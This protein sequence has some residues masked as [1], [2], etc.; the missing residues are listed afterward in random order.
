MSDKGDKVCPICTEEMDLTDQQ[1]NPCQCGYQIC[2]WCW[3]H[4]MEMAEKVN[5][6]GRCPACRTAY[7][8]EKIVAAAENCERLVAEINSE[9]KQK[10][11]KAKPKAPEGKMYLCDFRVIQRN[12]VYIIGLPLNLADEELL[13]RR[14]Y[15]GQYGKV[16]K[17]SISRTTTGA[18]QH[19]SNNSC[20]VYITYSKEDDAIL[21]IQSVHSFVLDGRPLRASFGT[22]KYCHAW[23]R[24]L[25]CINPDCLYLHDFGSDEDRFFKDD[26]VLAFQRS[27]VQQIIGTTNNM[28]RSGDVLPP[29]A[30][31]A[32]CNRPST[33]R[34]VADS[35]ARTVKEESS[36]KVHSHG[37]LDPWESADEGYN[38]NNCHNDL[39]NKNAGAISHPSPAVENAG[40]P[41]HC[42]PESKGKCGDMSALS[43]R[44][45]LV[46]PSQN[47]FGISECPGLEQD[48]SDQIEVVSTSSPPNENTT[49]ANLLICNDWQ[50]KNLEGDFH[51]PSVS[52]PPRSK[53]NATS[54]SYSS[55]QRD[56]S[57]YQINPDPISKVVPSNGFGL[58]FAGRNGTF[59]YSDGLS[60]AG[61]EGINKNI[62]MVQKN[63]DF[64]SGENKIIS[65]I[66]SIDFDTWEDSL[67]SPQMLVELLSDTDRQQH[68]CLKVPSLRKIADCKQSKFSFA[69]QDDFFHHTSNECSTSSGLEEN[70]GL[71]MPYYENIFPSFGPAE[72]DNQF[73]KF[74]GTLLQ[75]PNSAP[76]GFP[77]VSKP[78][79]GFDNHGRTQMTFN[80]SATQFLQTPAPIGHS[81]GDFEFL[82]PAILEVRKGMRQTEINNPGQN[83][84]V[85]SQL[86]SEHRNLTSANHRNTVFPQSEDD[87]ILPVLLEQFES[88]RGHSPFMQSSVIRHIPNEERWSDDVKPIGDLGRSQLASKMEMD[89]INFLYSYDDLKS[90]M[91]SSSNVY[92]RGYALDYDNFVQLSSGKLPSDDAWF[93]DWGRHERVCMFELF[94]VCFKRKLDFSQFVHM[95]SNTMPSLQTALPPELANNAIRLYRECL[96]R[97]KYIGSKQYNTEL[98]VTMVRG[99]F[100]KHM[101]ETDPEKIQKLKDEEVGAV[102]TSIHAAR[103]LINHMLYETEKMSGQKLSK[104]A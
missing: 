30:D 86:N 42:F 39:L 66:L 13:Q 84:R 63:A 29:P 87:R 104:A 64:D 101:H 3:N 43:S 102:D 95:F 14:E 89:L 57:N 58:N 60:E 55:W 35:N 12:L 21:C 11:Q 53:L 23:L 80:D 82:D 68:G 62:S 46:P 94:E 1:L 69:R 32:N 97:A 103:G 36:C 26:L 38:W 8:K 61:L 99:Q 73:S 50:M 33:G 98:V 44:G 78:P 56:E 37:K 6:E 27:K 65:K 18:I 74:P 59:G 9:R 22:T 75:S 40:I 2:V 93:E 51:L 85:Y 19:S 47:L 7:D 15:F 16:L 45:S 54:S 5:T 92:N 81:V 83:M 48:T 52:E 25:P 67:A 91:S 24:N 76:P 79:P 41:T 17:V 4:I 70:K 77:A 34:P 20:C 72:L 71:S 49:S 28:H 10:S 90:Q 100:K 88:N 31:N 96:R